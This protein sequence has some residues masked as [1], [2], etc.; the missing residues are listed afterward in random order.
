MIKP[1]DIKNQTSMSFITEL[2]TAFEQRRNTDNAA[3]MEKYMKKSF[4]FFW[5]KNRG[6][7]SCF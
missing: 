2:E 7:K 1:W 6:K 3:P 4:L 5:F